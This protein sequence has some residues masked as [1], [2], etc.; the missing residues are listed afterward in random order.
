MFRCVHCGLPADSLYKEYSPGNIVLTQCS[1]CHNPVDPYLE[2]DSV[3]QFIDMLLHKPAIY[4]HLLF[5]VIQ[6]QVPKAVLK[7][8]FLIILFDIYLKWS[9]GSDPITPA[10]FCYR[11]LYYAMVAIL[12]LLIFHSTALLVARRLS[13]RVDSSLISLAL[14]I[15]SYGRL[16]HLLMVIWD[17]GPRGEYGWILNPFVLTSNAEAIMVILDAYSK[18]GKKEAVGNDEKKSVKKER[19]HNI[20]FES[21]YGKAY[22]T[23]ASAALAK[24]TLQRIMALVDPSLPVS[25]F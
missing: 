24:Y 13:P 15:S 12:E 7:L 14:I 2:Y 21:Y 18:D 17:E 8:G 5:N 19:E 3:I 1:H 9:A 25:L 4:R 20:V 6:D 23:V 11:Y 22:L 16:L 10:S